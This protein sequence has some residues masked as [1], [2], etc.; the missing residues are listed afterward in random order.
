MCGPRNRIPT[1]SYPRSNHPSNCNKIQ[2]LFKMQ[3][4]VGGKCQVP[5][6]HWTGTAQPKEHGP[7]VLVL[8]RVKEIRNSTA[9]W[10][11]GN[12]REV[13]HCLLHIHYVSKPQGTSEN[14]LPR[15]LYFSYKIS[16][17]QSYFTRHAKKK[18]KEKK[19][20]K[21]KN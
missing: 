3:K 20:L 14:A 17:I 2:C 12:L 21:S 18:K 9:S 13:P 10:E 15:A 6:R 8:L 16:G 11:R 1:S 19:W 4:Q 7:P 5:S